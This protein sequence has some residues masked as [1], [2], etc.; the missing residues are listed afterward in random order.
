SA[1]RTVRVLDVGCGT[2]SFVKLLGET[3]WPIEVVG[4]DYSPAMCVVA[5]KK[6]GSAETPRRAVVL[7]GD[8]EHLPF[9]D[10]SV[11]VITCANSFHH[12]PRQGAVV[13]ELRR[14][15]RAGGRLILLDGF[16]D[17]VIGWFVFDVV[18]AWIET[19]VHHAAWR[20]VHTMF[21]EAGFRNIRRRKFNVL[22][23]VLV[24]TGDA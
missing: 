9:P 17:N 16:R 2:A 7:A 23:P 18:V 21:V 1:P 8:S 11:D 5:A 3:P 24:T 14:V 6:L 13:R 4:V 12:Y 10:G 15:L 20:E 22:F 19:D